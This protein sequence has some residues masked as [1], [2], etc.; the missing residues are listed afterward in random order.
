MLKSAKSCLHASSLKVTFTPALSNEAMFFFVCECGQMRNSGG[1]KGLKVF[2]RVAVLGLVSGAIAGCS[3]D[4]GRFASGQSADVTGS[5]GPMNRAGAQAASAPAYGMQSYANT[6]GGYANQ[7]GAYA[8]QAG[9]YANQAGGYANQAGQAV[10]SYGGQAASYASQSATYANQTGQQ[11]YNNATNTVGSH[12]AQ[13]GQTLNA[14][15]AGAAA[16]QA[17]G[18]LIATQQVSAAANQ[19]N[20][21]IAASPV[22]KPLPA[23]RP[24]VAAAAATAAS[25]LEAKP[26]AAPVAAAT[27]AD[28]A[29]P[30]VES[31]AKV[32]DA[33]E[34]VEDEPRKAGSGPQFRAPVRGRVIAGFGPKPGGT[35]N[36]GVNF[37]VPAGT[38]VRSAE[39]GV[40]AYSG[41]ELKGYGN[42]VLVKHSDGY[43]TAYAHNSELTVKKG[44][45]VRRGQ[46]IAK[47]GQTGN[48]QSPQLHFE[49]R[50][51]STPVDP[52]SYVAGL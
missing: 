17:N 40:V 5:L 38:S 52:S 20:S 28:I 3:S 45:K 51:G 1:T 18:Q 22:A 27:V 36:E 10:Q 16:Y 31:P 30:K 37:A 15:Q 12:V 4:I 42:L 23:A 39:D 34:S 13:A 47:A 49:I 26:L 21:Q 43:V 6:A 50:K 19:V 32:A 35:R 48:V 9:A 24:V 25:T 29:K 2:A 11:L 14:A 8:N 7:A 44:E 41:N 33:V 46:I